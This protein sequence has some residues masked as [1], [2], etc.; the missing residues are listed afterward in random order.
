M[1]NDASLLWSIVAKSN[2]LLPKRSRQVNQVGIDSVGLV[3][4]PGQDCPTST[5]ITPG[6]VSTS[7]S[8]TVTES[9]TSTATQAFITTSSSTTSSTVLSS[10]TP[11]GPTFCPTCNVPVPGTASEAS[12]PGSDGLRY[13]TSDG[14][15]WMLVCDRDYGGSDIQ[16]YGVP[17]LTD[18]INLCITTGCALQ[19]VRS[20]DRRW[21]L[22]LVPNI[23]CK[24]RG[25]LDCDI[26]RDLS[27]DS[28]SGARN[29]G[30][31]TET[32]P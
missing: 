1:L 9:F 6:V 19:C 23:S 16:S 27:V 31:S 8:T 32:A 25:S 12:C 2:E 3:L 5:T 14:S 7:F 10:G 21:G 20:R 28:I 13:T 22:T 29:R 11:S 24:D 30:G 18:C 17:S 4:S 15:E 26:Q